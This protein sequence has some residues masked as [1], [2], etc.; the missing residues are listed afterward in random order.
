MPVGDSLIRLAAT[1]PDGWRA[2]SLRFVRSIHAS[3]GG[4]K[5]IAYGAISVRQGEGISAG[6]HGW[7]QGEHDSHRGGDLLRRLQHEIQGLGYVVTVHSTT[8]SACRP[9]W[10]LADAAA[11]ARTLDALA[12]GRL[13]W[14]ERARRVRAQA[15]RRPRVF[16]LRQ[17]DELIW[18]ALPSLRRGVTG[19]WGV[20]SLCLA[21]GAPVLVASIDGSWALRSYV[22]LISPYGVELDVEVQR[23]RATATPPPLVRRVLAAIPVNS[24]WNCDSRWLCRRFGR[25]E[26]GLRAALATAAELMSPPQDNSRPGSSAGPRRARAPARARNRASR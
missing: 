3:I 17:T 24:T 23:P 26:R 22:L 15:P 19:A 6:I 20:E 4:I 18:K 16:A 1:R 13:V 21:R 25:T 8:F 5:V 2:Y 10:G 11:E 14:A 7:L 9:L 12:L